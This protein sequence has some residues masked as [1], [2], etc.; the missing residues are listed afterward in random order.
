MKESGPIIT[1]TVNGKKVELNDGR[2]Q[3]IFVD[4]FNYIDFDLTKPQGSMVL[5]LNGRQACFT[6]IIKSGDVVDIYWKQ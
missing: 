6:D 3:Y 1:L 4:L 2:E 5:M